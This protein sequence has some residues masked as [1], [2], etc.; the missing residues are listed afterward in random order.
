MKSL[1]VIKPVD[2]AG[3]VE[4]PDMLLNLCS[5]KIGDPL[6][7]LIDEESIVLKKCVPVCLFCGCAEG[8]REYKGKNVCRD[9]MDSLKSLVAE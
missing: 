8:V 9:C 2:N 4:I 7:I 3:R 5:V 6:E 1:S